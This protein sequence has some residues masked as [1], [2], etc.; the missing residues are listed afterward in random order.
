[1]KKKLGF[2]VLPI[3]IVLLFL[4]IKSSNGAK[5][6]EEAINPS[7]PITIIHEEKTDK[8]SIVFYTHEGKNDFST[9]FVRK[10]FNGYKYVYGGGQQ[11]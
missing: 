5:T 11:M 4:V 9:C 1:M 2:I 7:I 10:T 6:I 3:M 8:G